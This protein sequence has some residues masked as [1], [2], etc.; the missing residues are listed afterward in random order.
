MLILAFH[1]DIDECTQ[2]THNCPA[3]ST[4]QNT[5]G[6]FICVC[7]PGFRIVNGLCVGKNIRSSMLK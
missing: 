6:S 5:P 4:C 1:V 3:F 2:G 7:R